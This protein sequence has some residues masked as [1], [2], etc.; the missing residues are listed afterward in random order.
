MKTYGFESRSGMNFSWHREPLIGDWWSDASVC[1]AAS[2][3]NIIN[4]S[5]GLV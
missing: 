2:V 5:V 3:Q 1:F 4:V